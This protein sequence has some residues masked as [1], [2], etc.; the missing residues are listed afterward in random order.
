[1]LVDSI[2]RI[3]EPAAQVRQLG[4]ANDEAAPALVFDPRL[5]G[6]EMP[7]A[8]WRPRSF[9]VGPIP[10]RDEDIAYA[11]VSSLSAWIR[12]GE[13]TSTR[14]TRLYLDRIER[15]AP[16]LECMVTV[17]AELAL[18]QA[19]EADREIGAGRY[20]G[21][22]HGVPYGAKDLF[23]TANIR[24]T[25]GA[26]PYRERVP[27]S[28]A[29]VID[30]LTEAGAV[31]LGKTALGALAYG[32]LW[33]DG[34]TRNPWNPEE[35]SGGSS[36]GSGAA[37]AAGLMP[38][39]LGTETLG[40]IENPASRNGIPGLRPTFGRVSRHGAMALCW[41]LD[42]VGVLARTSEDCLQVLDLLNG[43]DERDPGSIAVPLAYDASLAVDGARVGYDPAWFEQDDMPDTVANIPNILREINVELTEIQLPDLP[44]SGMVPILHAEAAAAH[45]GLVLG[46]DV[47]RLRGQTPLAWPNSIRR[48]RFISAV[49]LIQAQRLRRKVMQEMDIIYA[50]LDAIVGPGLMNPA[51]STPM[52]LITNFT[53]QPSLT[54]PTGYIESPARRSALVAPE[55]YGAESSGEARRVPV[56][57]GLWGRLFEEGRLVRLGTELERALNIVERPPV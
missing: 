9:T 1:M 51:L 40:S 35:G 43:L 46:G 18:R 23:D 5:P 15:I 57:V 32:D 12:S 56:S 47:D 26:E 30:R 49:D 19:E 13:L 36:A 25:W 34:L 55:F 50:G 11:P 4:L 2:E 28:N 10:G 52:T 8:E 48:A 14:L 41:S 6:T 31:L 20:R 54:I 39:A 21:P 42:K 33:F 38:F 45:E 7:E 22:L 44:F 27:E 53:G 17:T 16:A 37:V 3:T 24:T 29:A